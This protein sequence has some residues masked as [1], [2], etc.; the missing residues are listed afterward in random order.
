LKEGIPVRLANPKEGVITWVCGLVHTN[1][2]SADEQMVYDFMDAFLAPESGAYLID[3]YGYGHSNQKAFAMV[4]Q[5]RLDE[6]GIHDPDEMISRSILS[7]GGQD[8]DSMMKIIT[9]VQ[10][11]S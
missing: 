4:S 5:E 1:K 7:G 3:V 10:A 8:F 9:E 6:L 11:G 2:G